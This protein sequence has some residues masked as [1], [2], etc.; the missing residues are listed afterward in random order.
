MLCKFGATGQNFSN[1]K[2]N[3]IFFPIYQILCH[4]DQ[5]FLRHNKPWKFGDF[6]IYSMAKRAGGRKWSSNMTAI[7]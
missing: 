4:S 3:G 7:I 5:R 2:E 6:S 1:A